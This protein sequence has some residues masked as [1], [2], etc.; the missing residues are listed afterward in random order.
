MTEKIAPTTGGFRKLNRRVVINSKVSVD[1]I[2][3]QKENFLF[4]TYFLIPTFLE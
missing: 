3:K 1:S 4:I 2:S